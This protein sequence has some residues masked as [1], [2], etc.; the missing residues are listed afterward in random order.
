MG[1]KTVLVIAG[2]DSSGGAGI[3]ADLRALER[4]GVS[5]RIAL[6]AVTAQTDQGVTHIE[7][8]GKESFLA[9]LQ[10]AGPIDAIKVGM[11]TDAPHVHGLTA[12][13]GSLDNPPPVVVDPVLVSTSGGQLLDDNGIAALWSLLPYVTLLTPNVAEAKV[14][15]SGAPIEDWAEA[16]PCAVL[17][18]GGDEGEDLIEDVLFFDEEEV[19]YDHERVPGS[20]RGT[21]CAL[22]SYIAAELAHGRPIDQAV[23]HG[24]LA[25]VDAL[26]S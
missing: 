26:K 5:A 18:T 13:L 24:I 20:F 25:L 19:G 12:W 22:A 2:S 10:A 11:L 1:K 6:T 23:G 7:G 3:A 16:M 9:Q 21:G 8:T 4:A 15:A 14:L 17:V